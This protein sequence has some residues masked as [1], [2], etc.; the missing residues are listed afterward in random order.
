MLGSSIDFL[1]CGL[2]IL[3]SRH[4]TN[5][6]SIYLTFHDDMEVT[7]ESCDVLPTSP[8]RT[9]ELTPHNLLLANSPHLSALTRNVPQLREMPHPKPCPFSGAAFISRLLHI[10]VQRYNPCDKQIEL[11]GILAQSSPW[12]LQRSLL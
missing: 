8:F 4:L 1:V 9:D 12:G 2:Q 7:L 11:R 3:P 6:S 5:P 10:A